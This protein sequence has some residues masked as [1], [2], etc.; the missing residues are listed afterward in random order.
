MLLIG[1]PSQQ[2]ENQDKKIFDFVFDVLSSLIF[3][4]VLVLE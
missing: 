2:N 4:L 1:Q 3:C